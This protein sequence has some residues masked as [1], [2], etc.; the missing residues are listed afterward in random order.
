M[1]RSSGI[2]RR[3]ANS[4]GAS[5]AAGVYCITLETVGEALDAMKTLPLGHTDIV[6]VSVARAK[7]AGPYH[8]MMGQNPVYIL[9]ADGV[10]DGQ[11]E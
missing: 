5:A 9:S 4:R 7:K 1:R 3:S 2:C 11:Q 8:M 6:S 10:P